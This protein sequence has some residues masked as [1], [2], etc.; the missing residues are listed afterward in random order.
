MI[1]LESALSPVQSLPTR[2]IQSLLVLLRTCPAS[3]NHHFTQL[4]ILPQQLFDSLY[5]LS[6]LKTLRATY[7]D[8][9]TCRIVKFEL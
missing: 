4:F 7:G 9:V 1:F 6:Q 5:H 8:F 2:T 3:F